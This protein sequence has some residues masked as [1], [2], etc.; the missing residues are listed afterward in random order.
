MTCPFAA[1]FQLEPSVLGTEDGVCLTEI[2]YAPEEPSA[3]LIL[4]A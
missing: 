4:L 2:S 1:A 3:F